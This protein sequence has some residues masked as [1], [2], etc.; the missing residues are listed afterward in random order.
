MLPAVVEMD[1]VVGDRPGVYLAGNLV[2]A[3]ADRDGSLFAFE[4][5]AAAST[6]PVKDNRYTAV[7]RVLDFAPRTLVDAVILGH[8][9]Q[10]RFDLLFQQHHPPHFHPS[11]SF[12][13][14]H[15]H[16]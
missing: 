10:E 15:V 2:F 8:P 12:D 14:I 1:T 4:K 7:E 6:F 13:A 16:P 9:I 11:P 5:S 3:S